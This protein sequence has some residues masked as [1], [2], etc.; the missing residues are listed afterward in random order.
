MLEVRR[1]RPVGRI[2]GILPVDHLGHA[3]QRL[4]HLGL[5]DHAVVQPVGDVLS[6]NAQG[7]AV[8]HQA[9]VVDIRH[10][11]AADALLDPAHHVTEDALAVV[12]QF[13]LNIAGAPG[14]FGTD[15]YAEQVIQQAV[16]LA[17]QVDQFQLALYRLHV[18]LVIVQGVQHGGG[19]RRHPGGVGAGFRVADLLLEHGCHQIRH[20]PHA[21]AD[22][23]LA[24]QTAGQADQ[25]VVALV[26]LDPGAGF[27]VALAQHRASLHGGVH[28]V[29]GAVEKAGVDEGHPRAGGLD[30]GL[31]VD[32]GTP[33]LVHDAHLQGARRHAQQLLDATEQLVGEGHFER[34]VH[35][36]F[37]D[38]DAAGA[39]V[40]ATLEVMQG[41]Q[42]GHHR[43]ED[44]LG[45]LM[46]FAI[47]DRR[48]AHQMADIAHEQQRAAV[49]GQFAAIGGGVDAIGV[50]APGDALAALVQL[51]GQVA[52]HQAQPVA[53][54]QHL[55]GGIDGGHRVL[56]VHDGGQRRFHQHVLHP[57]GVGAADGAG[58]V[59]LDLEVQAVV[60][61]QH[62]AR[63]GGLALEADEFLRLRQGSLYTAAQG[64]LQLAGDHGIGAD[65]GVRALGQRRGLVE[66]G[67]GEGDHLGAAHF[68]VARPLAGATLFADRIGAVQ[69]VVQRSPAGI[70]GV[71]C[72][73][74]VHHRHHQLRAGLGGDLAVDIGGGRLDLLRLRQQIADGFEEGAV[75]AHVGDRAGMGAMPGIQL[76]LQAITLGQQGAVARCQ[77][78]YQ[79]IETAPEGRRLDTAAGQHFAFDELLELGGYLQ[80]L[81]LH[82][83]GH[84][85]VL[86]CASGCLGCL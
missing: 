83:F 1:H 31:E 68:V 74:G 25:H 77:V 18:D 78:M 52:L 71:Q 23:R 3:L 65:V 84:F 40:A 51:L 4:A 60:L 26:G 22:L 72:V 11:G 13:L 79:R 16:A 70:G 28:L 56:A 32:A 17:A 9:D 86:L 36:R 30:A 64:N 57:G 2:A 58:R 33:L 20:G 12:V 62:G 55:V 44:A 8:F 61:Q 48:V 38:I 81:T 46:A 69:G 43:I 67:A 35:L 59:D 24:T 63:R 47:D 29:A 73:A 54:D 80:A 75:G 45:N 10:L 19:R 6:R 76:A 7:G 37:D 85:P 66:E 21:L 14:A 39:R 5:A 15:R 41:D 50:E 27:H 53:V 49:Q 42:A 34:P 82:A